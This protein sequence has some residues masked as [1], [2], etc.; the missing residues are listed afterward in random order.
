MIEGHFYKL[1]KV[2][3]VFVKKQRIWISPKKEK[4]LIVFKVENNYLYGNALLIVTFIDSR[5]RFL[6]KKIYKHNVCDMFE[7]VL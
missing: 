4:G 2:I 1:K 7:F 6:T 5:G 3:S